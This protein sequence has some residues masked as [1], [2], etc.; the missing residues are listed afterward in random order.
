[1]F[2]RLRTAVKTALD[3]IVTAAFLIGWLAAWPF[4]LFYWRHHASH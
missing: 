3:P 2:N 1:M 4:Y